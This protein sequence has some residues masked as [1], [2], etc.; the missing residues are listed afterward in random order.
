MKKFNESQILAFAPNANALANAKKICSSK[1]FVKRMR[2]EDDSFYMGECK[3]SG[4]SNYTVSADFINEA[5]PVFRCS[6]PSRQLPCKHSIALLL[7]INS[8]ADFEI[9]SLP[10]DILQKR[11]KLEARQLK[12]ENTEAD[13]GS[14]KK[15]AAKSVSKAAKTKKIKKQLEGLELIRKLVAQLMSTGLAAMGSVSLKDYR[16]LSKQLGDYYLPGPRVLFNK[17]IIEIESYHKD[18]DKIHY[19]NAVEILKRLRALEKKSAEYLKNKLENELEESAEDILYEGLGGIW[20]LE[21]LNALGLKKENAE[22]IQLSFEEIFDRARGE[23]IDKAY[24]IELE[25]GEVFFTANY[26]PVK[27]LKYVKQEDSCFALLN[28]PVLS[29]YPGGINKRIRWESAKFGEIKTEQFSLIKN[30]A[31]KDIDSAVK[32]VKNEIKN[33][34]SDNEVAVCVWFAR[35]ISIKKSDGSMRTVLED[36]N[37][38]LLELKAEDEAG[39]ALNSLYLLPDKRFLN[40]QV[41][42]GKIA[43]DNENRQM[44]MQPCSIITDEGIL[45]LEY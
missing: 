15:S 4:K 10:E 19:T 9:I 21:Q 41:I 14:A 33:I 2:T 13:S 36:A 45:R 18:G 42:F 1:A 29:Y 25:S 17:L 39:N 3:G 12:K 22:I 8:G 7:E 44:Y 27:A 26:R 38:K 31:Y 23:F 32:A 5:N 24:W 28:I 40:N 34:L 16:E 43:Y 20:K 11:Q 6:C 30:H 37:K 35:I